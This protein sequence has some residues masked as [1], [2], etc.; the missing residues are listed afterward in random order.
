MSK[1]ILPVSRLSRAVLAATSLLLLAPCARAV[2]LHYE[3]ASGSVLANATEPGLVVQTS[4]KDTLPGTSFTIDNN[5]SFTFA[6][7]SIWSDEPKIGS[8]DLISS[9]VSAT[10]NFLDPLTG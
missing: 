6:F 9:P 10:L 1:A 3:L 5:G 7:F 2:P 8:D 4:V